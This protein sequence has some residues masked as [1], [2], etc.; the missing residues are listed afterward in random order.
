MVTTE[1]NS[2]A[3]RW[4][5]LSAT[6]S[7]AKPMWSGLLR[8]QFLHRLV[9]NYWLQNTEQRTTWDI[10]ING[11]KWRTWIWTPLVCLKILCHYF[12]GSTEANYGK[13]SCGGR[14]MRE[15]KVRTLSLCSRQSICYIYFFK[16]YLRS[17]I[18]FC[19]SS[20]NNFTPALLVDFI[21]HLVSRKWGEQTALVIL[22]PFSISGR[23]PLSGLDN[24]FSAMRRR[25]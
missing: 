13:H 10:I 4:K 21:A 5:Y 7:T 2:N 14:Y 1:G 18:Q 11:N 9:I 12:F 19:S 17:G 24:V 22:P 6:S 20:L 23:R 16:F 25:E 8:N 15:F 3:W